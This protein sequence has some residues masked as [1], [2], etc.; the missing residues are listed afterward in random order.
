MQIKEAKIMAAIEMDRDLAVIPMTSG[1]RVT[2]SSIAFRNP[3]EISSNPYIILLQA[4]AQ[5]AFVGTAHSAAEQPI[6]VQLPLAVKKSA[7]PY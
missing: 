3:A 5:E 6:F 2:I 1:L 4:V 7:W